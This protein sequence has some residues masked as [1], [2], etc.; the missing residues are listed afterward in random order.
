MWPVKRV[1]R[2]DELSQILIL[3]NGD[4]QLWSVHAKAWSNKSQT[5][6]HKFIFI[7]NSLFSDS[8]ECNVPDATDEPPN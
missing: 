2:Y 4:T 8:L 5:H 7:I 6:T 1:D 3:G